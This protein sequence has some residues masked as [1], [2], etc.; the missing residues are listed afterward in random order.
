[1]SKQ[2][3]THQLETVTLSVINGRFNQIVNEMDTKLVNS[4]FSPIICEAHDMTNGLYNAEGGTVT[5]GD[6]GNPLFIGNMEY[7]IKAILD[8]FEGKINR[9]DLFITNDPYLG[10]THLM[11]VKL[12]QP[13]FDENGELLVFVA[14]TGHWQD[15]GG[16]TPGGFNGETVEIYQE[17]LQIP[18]LKLIEK[19][20]I[21]ES[22]K[23]IIFKNVRQAE[24]IEGDYKAQKNAISHGTKQFREL[25]DDFEKEKISQALNSLASRSERQMRSRIEEIPDGIYEYVDQVDNDGVDDVPLPIQL[26]MEISG[27]SLEFDFAGSAD[28]CR[29]PVN[30]SESGT[31]GACNIALKHIYPDIPI[32]S[33]FFEPLDV[34]IPDGSFLKAKPP[35]AVVGYTATMNRVIDTVHGALGRAIPDHVPA[36]SFSTSAPLTI[37]ADSEAASYSFTYPGAGGYGGSNTQDGLTYCT[38]PLARGR[39]PAVE[40]IEDRHP[41]RFIERSI[42]PDSGGAGRNRGGLGSVY[43]IEMLDDVRLS[44]V[45]DRCDHLPEGLSGGKPAKGFE[46]KLRKGGEE[47][48]PPLRSKAQNIPLSAGDSVRVKLPGGG[49]YDPPHERNPSRVLTDVEL[50][51]VSEK[52][53]RETYG[54]S[55]RTTEGGFEID[56]DETSRLRNGN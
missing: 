14:N 36:Q 39:A 8:E 37:G 22:V 34:H 30:L 2:V 25:I 38:P 4:A 26:T 43:T 45:A 12:V 10:G 7:T 11:D 54:V 19:G 20:E 49:G 1:M 5:Q 24:D 46:L 35:C 47:F 23:N 51:Y 17:G 48:A 3:V 56:F 15:I 13:V 27:S 28:R 6:I 55:I 29:G 32:N 33:G 42:R 53:A 40:V 41:V 18:P 9:G 50:G 16:I 52:E 44:M 21:N 31:V